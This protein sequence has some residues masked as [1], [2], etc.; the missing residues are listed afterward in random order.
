MDDP[1]KTLLDEARALS[2]TL[3]DVTITAQALSRH[4]LQGFRIQSPMG[5]A[6]VSAG[7]VPLE[8]LTA[9]AAMPALLPRLCDAVA[10]E[11]RR[12][13]LLEDFVTRLLVDT[14][15]TTR[16]AIAAHAD[17]PMDLVRKLAADPDSCVRHAVTWRADLPADI[18]RK[19]AAD[20]FPFVRVGI[21]DHATLP[22]DLITQLAKDSDPHVRWVIAERVKR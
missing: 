10:A 16:T 21:A 1:T 5:H 22:E 20:P 8:T 12:V 3:A 14:S 17:L 4:S 19:L 2:A 11:R 7:H 6:F 13:D 15:L 18:V 9:V